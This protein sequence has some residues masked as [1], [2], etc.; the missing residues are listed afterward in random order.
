MKKENGFG[1][2]K[3]FRWRGPAAFAVTAAI[4]TMA[5]LVLPT[6]A[7]L[8]QTTVFTTQEPTGEFTDGVSYEMGMKFQSTVAGNITAIRYWQTSNESGSHIG[9][10]WDAAGNELATST[11]DDPAPG[12]VPGWQQQTL[13]SPLAIQPNTTYVVSVNINSYYPATV[14]GLANPVINNELSSVA[15]GANGVYVSPPGNFPNISFNN[16]NYFCDV[17]FVAGGGEPTACIVG[18]KY[19]S[20]TG[21]G[22]PFVRNSV[23]VDGGAIVPPEN[24]NDLPMASF[25]GTPVFYQFVIKNC[26]NVD[27][28]NVRLDD[29]I[30]LREVGDGG[31]LVGGANGNC[32]ENPRL[33]PA[34]PDRIVA[35]KLT[36][37]ESVTVTS[38]DFPNDPISTVDIC[39]TFGRDRV[40][41]IVRNDSQVE[42]DADLDGNGSGET[43]VFF[44]DLNLVQCKDQPCI[45]V[46]K[47]VR[48][49]NADGSMTE[50]YDA[51]KCDDPAIPV[52]FSDKDAEYR[53]IVTN[54]GSETLT[55][56]TVT[57]AE[58]GFDR[59]F[60]NTMLAPGASITVGKG[61]IPEFFKEGVC[62][63]SEFLNTI[64]VSAFGTPSGN[65]VADSDTACVKCGPCVE[66]VKEVSVD[67]FP[68]QSDL[69]QWFDA[70]ACDGSQ[71]TVPSTDSGAEYRLIVKNC[72]PEDLNNFRLKDNELGFDQ[73]FP[74][75]NLPAGNE[76]IVDAVS[77]PSLAQFLIN[78]SVC[79][80][81]EGQF[82]NTAFV[83]A[84]GAVS[85]IEVDDSDPACVTCADCAIT[86]D[87]KCLVVPPPAGPFDCDDKVDALKMIWD[88]PG[89]LESVIAYRGKVGE[90]EIPVSI[91]N[92]NPPVV[93]VSGY[94]PSTND[95]QWAWSSDIASGISQF[96]LSCSDEDMN[97]PEDCGTPQGD[98]KNEALPPA[99]NVWLLDGLTTDKGFVLDCT[100]Q[101]AEALD[102]CE[103][104]APP[105]PNCETLGKPTSLT[106]RYTGLGCSA[107]SNNQGD[108]SDCSGETGSAPVTITILKDPSKI[109][110][111][112][113]SGINVGDLVT[114]SAIGSDMG[115]EI[116][117]NVGGQFLKIHTS[118]S[119]PLAAGD[120]FGSLELLQFNGLGSGAEVTYSY[121]VTNIG[122]FAVDITSVFDDK[123][124]ELL[125]TPVTLQ[126]KAGPPH[127]KKPRSSARPPPMR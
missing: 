113:S 117:L 49:V 89:T 5:L 78:D 82:L 11:F 25:G 18:E 85:M 91:S 14:G 12:T 121:E 119:A 10:I 52:P 122:N 62:P 30:D 109:Q 27:L 23:T 39:E 59:N 115:S 51:N 123:L 99:A 87:K 97:G 6:G 69:K 16:T 40:E 64:T 81:S 34:D 94:Q 65:E 33:I 71:G 47:E 120:V 57:D 44:D 42:A 26:G 66:L 58:L 80:N 15:D 13:M 55:N 108:K 118:C 21:P 61:T 29:C 124:G 46:K 77:V 112:P 96:H 67:D 114:V 3:R 43:F 4:I 19:V 7:A 83:F 116:Q 98:G 63:D 2:V 50:W 53:L 1:F 72:G 37:G 102:N 100:P 125:E 105:P 28:Y 32:V 9:R 20:V 31:F 17:V 41:G 22:G 73:N 36:P 84:K 88:G 126:P 76:F 93:T 95:V 45:D 79:P 8:A 90:E 107:S 24:L 103:F 101:P 75:F 104:E 110:V 86:I 127:V 38:A 56:F 48:G 106:F 68:T 54:C 70:N 35:L 60:P 111:N 92:D 74:A